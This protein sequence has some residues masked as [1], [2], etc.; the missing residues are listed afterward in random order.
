MMRRAAALL[1][2]ATL[3]AVAGCPFAP[4]P[5]ADPSARVVILAQ[6]GLTGPLAGL[7]PARAPSQILDPDALPDGIGE[8]AVFELDIATARP[9]A[10]RLRLVSRDAAGELIRATSADAGSLAADLAAAPGVFHVAPRPATSPPATV[11]ATVTVTIPTA[12]LD[13][14]SR[15]EVFTRTAADGTPLD[16]DGF[17]LVRGFF[18]M[19]VL[20]DSVSWGN[21]LPDTDKYPALVARAIEQ[22]TQLRVVRQTFAHSGAMIVPR[23]SD[24]L[25]TANCSGEVPTFTTSVSAQVDLLDRPELLD[26]VLVGGCLNDVSVRDLL[27]TNL[28]EAAIIEQTDLF[29]GEAM[30]SLLRQVRTAAPQARVVVTGYY[31]VVSTLS[32]P[33][34]LG[35]WLAARSQTTIE[36]LAAI[37]EKLAGQ[38]AV[39]LERSDLAIASAVATVAAESPADPGIAFAP[40]PFGPENAAFAPEAWLWGSTDRHPLAEWLGLDLQIFPEDPLADF[41]YGECN[42]PGVIPGLIECIYASV[43]HPNREGAVVYRDAIV[44][45]LQ[46][47]GVLHASE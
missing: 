17:P 5:P 30:A 14:A 40:V 11:T 1:L 9:G 44:E 6:R 45:A 41:R 35:Q 33:L 2:A 19:A 34:K 15:L 3:T 29:C 31:P 36:D 13:P 18:H 46:T 32:D 37:V 16:A 27:F 23:D 21:G 8:L 26:L 28:S 43:A 39:F 25:C 42:R 4:P 47:L 22:S 24:I 10:L 38:S 20:G 12:A 7:S